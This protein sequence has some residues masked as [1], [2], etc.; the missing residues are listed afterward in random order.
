MIGAA[1]SLSTPVRDALVMFVAASL[2]L[3]N[4]PYAG[5]T[6]DAVIYGLLALRQ[7]A[8][9]AYAKDLFFLFGSQNDYS[10]FT[11]IFSFLVKH[12]GLDDGAQIVV[13]SG[14]ALWIFAITHLARSALGSNWLA[15]V[16]VFV[17]A[18]T[19]FSYSPNF[20]TFALNESFATARSWAFPL[21]VTA[22]SF[23]IRGRVWWAALFG[24]TATGIHP[25]LGVWP[26]VIWLGI[27]LTSRQILVCLLTIVGLLVLG[28]LSGM[29]PF[30]QLMEPTWAQLVKVSS[31]DVFVG[32]WGTFR[33]GTI[34]F[35][36]GVLMLAGRLGSPHVRIWYSITGLVLVWSVLVSL[37]SSLYFPVSL[38]M[39]TQPWRVLWLA[40]VM[41]VVAVCDLL[42]QTTKLGWVGLSGSV[43]IGVVG[44]TIDWS[45]GWFVSVAPF[46]LLIVTS[47]TRGRAYCVAIVDLLRSRARAAGM[48]LCV[49]SIAMLP[50][51]LVPLELLGGGLPE[52]WASEFAYIWGFFLAGGLGLG[53]LFLAYALQVSRY[54]FVVFV[55]FM[56]VFVHAVSHWDARPSRLKEI[57]PVIGFANVDPGVFSI[58]RGEVV[59][60]PGAGLHTWF[61]LGTA[62]YGTSLQATG[63]VFSKE[64]A[65]EVRARLWRVT[66]A[67][68]MKD[69]WSAESVQRAEGLAS[70]LLK[71][72][73]DGGYSLHDYPVGDLKPGGVVYLCQDPDLDW[74]VSPNKTVA[75]AQG[76]MVPFAAMIGRSFYAHNCSKFRELN[77]RAC[78]Q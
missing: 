78:S 49:V 16:P 37:V 25:L 69:D 70:D 68:Q 62:N 71:S 45:I 39:M 11:P 50:S 31:I 75:D 72:R 64:K 6:H 60:W 65:I 76:E 15:G 44:L 13:L 41:G 23:A 61:L 52:G 18:A 22:I 1:G 53:W 43:L 14:A 10:I 28:P 46:V 56:P 17:L 55:G 21:A 51:Y 32:E 12:F 34:I 33:A 58:R 59:A 2:W 5:V 66:V 9:E 57:E 36:V 27:H 29:L 63:I 35:W 26:I 8:P 40:Y 20:S 54:A 7:L 47:S 42:L 24:F 48:M 73:K 4:H 77:P 67:S 30:L 3:A 74:A 38:V 19:S